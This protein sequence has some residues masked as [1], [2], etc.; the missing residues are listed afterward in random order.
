MIVGNTTLCSYDEIHTV[1]NIYGTS[2]FYVST[3]FILESLGENFL[4]YRK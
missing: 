2:T 3:R 1:V 4:F